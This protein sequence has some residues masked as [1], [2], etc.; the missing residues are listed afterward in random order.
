MA[1]RRRNRTLVRIQRILIL[2]LVIA[3]IGVGIFFGAK[4]IISILD[5]QDNASETI[6]KKEVDYIGTVVIDAGHGGV[7]PG[8]SNGDVIEKDLTLKYSLAI[9]QLLEDQGVQVIY[10]RTDDTNL[11]MDTYATDANGTTATTDLRARAELGEQYDADYFVSIH[12]DSVENGAGSGHTVYCHSSYEDSVDLSTYIDTELAKITSESGNGIKDGSALRVIRL[13]TTVSCLVELGYITNDVSYLTSDTGLSELS[14]AVATGILN[15]LQA[16]MI[17]PD[18][19][20]EKQP[21]L[22]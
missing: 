21:D 4:K 9:G 3:V 13:N 17:N 1:R 14:N 12:I 22:Y 20:L 19:V 2:V 8:C 11:E 15:K 10:T 18:L 16:G 7:D 6:T 5:K